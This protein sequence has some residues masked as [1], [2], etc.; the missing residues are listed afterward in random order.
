MIIQIIKKRGVRVKGTLSKQSKDQ[1]DI[2][3]KQSDDLSVRNLY[4]RVYSERAT[5]ERTLIAR[6]PEK[7]SYVVR[8][9]HYF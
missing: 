8:L 5:V 4:M 3:S 1:H 6:L 2:Q 7:G 9:L